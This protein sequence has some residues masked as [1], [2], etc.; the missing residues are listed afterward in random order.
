MYELDIV[1]V[2]P[3]DAVAATFHH[4]YATEHEGRR[5]DWLCGSWNAAYAKSGRLRPDDNWDSLSKTQHRLGR[6][7][8][9]WWYLGP[10]NGYD[11]FS[12]M[13]RNGPLLES[14]ECKWLPERQ[15]PT[16]LMAY[17]VPCT[18]VKIPPAS[19]TSHPPP[20]LPHVFSACVAV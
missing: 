1:R 5:Y 7:D 3:D 13:L 11:G 14:G 8:N 19:V 18:V 20:P 6:F 17:Y 15:F 9:S 12:Q 2:P 10:N 4:F 16:G